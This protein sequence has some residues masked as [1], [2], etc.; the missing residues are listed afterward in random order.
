VTFTR[1][2]H[3]RECVKDILET[4]KNGNL[5]ILHDAGKGMLMTYF[6]TCCVLMSGDGAKANVQ[7][8]L[9][10]LVDVSLVLREK[11]RGSGKRKENYVD[12]RKE[13]SKVARF[14][15]DTS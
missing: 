1:F 13:G 9:K 14:F 4:T 2:A 11:R 7:A 6:V 10:K 12:R 5:V 3:P 15:F 8:S